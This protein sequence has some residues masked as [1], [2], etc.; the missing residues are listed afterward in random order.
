MFKAS[1]HSS[2]NT[3]SHLS[4][5]HGEVMVLEKNNKQKP[6]PNWEARMGKLS[7]S[8]R[9]AE[10]NRKKEDFFPGKDSADEKLWAVENWLLLSI[11]PSVKV[12]SFP[13]SVGTCTWLTWTVILCWAHIHASLLEKY[14]AI[15]FRSTVS[16]QSLGWEEWG[17]SD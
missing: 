5:I 1:L 8:V 14:L 17:G 4:D 11:L 12:F 16:T 10:S 6:Q 3:E 2:P 7:H 9:I 13:G 15:C